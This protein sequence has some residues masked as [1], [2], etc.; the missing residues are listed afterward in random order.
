MKASDMQLNIPV[1]IRRVNNTSFAGDKRYVVGT[2]GL[3]I[4]TDSL[5]EGLNPLYSNPPIG[6]PGNGGA[7]H[8]AYD[9]S[10]FLYLATLDGLAKLSVLDNSVPKIYDASDPQVNSDRFF[11]VF[12]LKKDQVLAVTADQYF[13]KQIGRAHV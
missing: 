2:Y 4:K 3:T 12:N 5:F 8:M 11:K 9:S 6:L 1:N 10:E 13:E 7:Y